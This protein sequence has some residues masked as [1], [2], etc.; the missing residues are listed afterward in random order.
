[1]EIFPQCFW[2]TLS[3]RLPLFTFIS[4]NISLCAFDYYLVLACL[5][6]EARVPV[7]Y[8]GPASVSGAAFLG[9]PTSPQAVK[10]SMIWTEDSFWPFSYKP[11]PTVFWGQYLISFPLHLKTFAFKGER[12]YTWFSCYSYSSVS[13]H[14]SAHQSFAYL[15]TLPSIFFMSPQWRSMEKS[16]QVSDNSVCVWNFLKSR[17]WYLQSYSNSTSSKS[18][19]RFIRF[20]LSTCKVAPCSLMF[21]HM[22][23]RALLYSYS[24]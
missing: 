11:C 12:A 2:P 1:M 24:S 14:F 3:F 21:H 17:L 5:V 13:T 15:P 16:L 22:K 18:L 19:K 10:M 20:L 7:G 9:D 4:Q 8:S 23:A 6:V